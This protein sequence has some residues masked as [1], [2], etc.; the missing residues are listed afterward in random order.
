[1]LEENSN[2]N[3]LVAVQD[4]FASFEAHVIQTLQQAMS[5]FNMHV[6]GQIERQKAMYGDMAASCQNIPPEF[7]WKKFVH[8]YG[9]VMVD[10]AAPERSVAGISYPNMSHRATTALISGTLE[11]K[12]RAIAGLGGYKA[13]Y[14]AVTPA[15]YLHQYDD[16]DDFGKSEPSPDL[17]LYLPDCSVG[18]LAGDRFNVKGKD[19]S[20]GKVGAA[21]SLSSELAFRA[22]SA[23]DAE[24]WWRAI[25]TCA[26]QNAMTAELPSPAT[27][28]STPTGAMADIK[29][30]RPVPLQ[31]QGLPAQ[32]QAMQQQAMQQQA[33]QHQGMQQEA[34]PVQAHG[35]PL[36]QQAGPAQTHGVPVQSQGVLAPASSAP[37]HPQGQGI[38]TQA[39][40]EA[41]E[42]QRFVQPKTG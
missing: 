33:M 25:S 28:G 36:Q 39:Q 16:R 6:G 20:K 15:K 27:A 12:G 24:R 40:G 18:A 2:K 11:R 34:M 42:S 8:R 9:T 23:A 5:A 7:E 13:A 17:S 4:A 14:Y 35:V 3:D 10:P 41:V 30:E 37:A 1:V 29:G 19:L 38:P 31:A 32:Q 22:G 26:G 21:L